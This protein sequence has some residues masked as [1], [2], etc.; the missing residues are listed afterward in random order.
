[1]NIFSFFQ[2]HYQKIF[3]QYD[4]QI[5]DAIKQTTHGGSMRYILEEK[6][7]ESKKKIKSLLEKEKRIK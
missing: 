7:K 5:I 4:F 2:L 1:M 6:I 3:E